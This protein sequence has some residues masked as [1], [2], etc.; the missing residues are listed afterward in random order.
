MK[1]QIIAYN[2]IENTS[3]FLKDTHLFIK[4]DRAV[5][6]K[7]SAKDISNDVIKKSE[8][9][10]IKEVVIETTELQ[11]I[12]IEAEVLAGN[13]EGKLPT[14]VLIRPRDAQPIFPMEFDEQGEPSNEMACLLVKSDILFANF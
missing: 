9:A 2:E 3:E 1:R 13:I 6:K 12:L 7:R 11:G 5:I 10:K 4:V 8:A 14:S